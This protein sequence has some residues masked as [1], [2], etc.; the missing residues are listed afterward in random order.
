[1]SSK[2]TLILAWVVSGAAL[3]IIQWMIWKQINHRLPPEQQIRKQVFKGMFIWFQKDGLLAQH[4]RLYPESRL[5][6]V[7]RVLWGTF[8]VLVAFWIVGR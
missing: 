4:A 2:K 1:M 8:W 5:T 7:F 6:T 3:A